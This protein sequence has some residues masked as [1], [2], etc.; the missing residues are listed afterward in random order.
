M[1]TAA[2]DEVSKKNGG[3]SASAFLAL[4]VGSDDAGLSEPRTA[5][6]L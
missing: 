1:L 4:R 2:E 3:V 6:Y 5:R